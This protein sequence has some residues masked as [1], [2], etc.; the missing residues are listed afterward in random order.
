LVNLF[1]MKTAVYQEA[2]D[3]FANPFHEFSIEELNRGCTNHSFKVTSR[4]N[5]RSFLLQ[6]INQ[7]VFSQPGHVQE[8]YEMLWKFLQTEQISF[9]IPEPKYFPDD[10]T[11]YV[12]SSDHYWRVFE[13]VSGGQV[14]NVAE[15]IDQARAVAQTFANFTLSF[16]E[17]ELNQLHITVPAMHDLS[18]RVKTFHQALHSRY[19][20]RLAK[21]SAL[22]EELRKR[23]RYA[24][25]YDVLTESEEFRQRVTHHDAKISNVIFD[26]DKKEVLCMVD[27][28]TVMPGY[29]FSDLG[30]LIRTMAGNKSENSIA[31]NELEVRPDY[32]DAIVKSYL[33]VL[34]HSLTDAEKKYV[35]FSGLM[36]TYLHALKYLSDYLEGDKNC[37]TDYREQ[38]F[39]RSYNQFTLLEKLEKFLSSTYDFRL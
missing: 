37:A 6:Q 24:S 34:D 25:F 38:N 3:A 31:L 23:E 1:R 22:V 8:N 35:H 30:E 11:L 16:G 19:Y 14:T 36:V 7:A 10:S 29:Y 13:Y 12:D 4:L 2:L 28:D 26:E 20:D 21:A 15:S 9:C 5:G 17:F 18:S 39:D 32:Y 33:A 27:L